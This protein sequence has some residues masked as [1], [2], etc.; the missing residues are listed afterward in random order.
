[1][2]DHA[3]QTASGW[4][5]FLTLE[6]ALVR[7]I[8]T[9]IVSVALIWGLDLTDL[10]DK[11]NETANIIGVLLPLLQAWWTRSAVTPSAQVVAKQEPNGELVAGVGSLFP[12]DTPVRRD[13]P[14][15]DLAHGRIR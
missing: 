8:V 14:V 5:R 15:G 4:R 12:T 10:G 7:G 1:M 11:V 9:A 13:V 6:P 3:L 2:A